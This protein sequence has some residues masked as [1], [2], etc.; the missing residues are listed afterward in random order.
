MPQLRQA[1]AG[2]VLAGH[3][4]LSIGEQSRRA[5]CGSVCTG[6]QCCA[7]GESIT[8]K[9]D[10]AGDHFGFRISMQILPCSRN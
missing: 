8:L 2:M 4:F 1:A 10:K 9:R 7:R 6:L 5:V 3:N